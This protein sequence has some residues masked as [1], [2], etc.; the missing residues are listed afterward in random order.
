MSASRRPAGGRPRA[1]LELV[2]VII[3]LLFVGVGL[4]PRVERSAT[5]DRGV[6]DLAELIAQSDGARPAASQV[7]PPEAGDDSWLLRSVL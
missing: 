7:A 5:A 2:F 4:R 3:T 1:A 6:T